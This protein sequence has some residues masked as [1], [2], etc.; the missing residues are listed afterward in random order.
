M[1]IPIGTVTALLLG[2]LAGCGGGNAPL[3]GVKDRSDPEYGLSVSEKL[4]KDLG[5][6]PATAKAQA[7]GKKKKSRR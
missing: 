2:L 6:D 1:K 7:A 4:K 5:A 3:E